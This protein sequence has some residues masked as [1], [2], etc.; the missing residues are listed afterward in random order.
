MSNKTNFDLE[1][2]FLET[3]KTKQEANRFFE[4][5]DLV[6]ERMYGVE[7]MTDAAIDECLEHT[8]SHREE[9][10]SQKPKWF[11]VL[12]GKITL[13]FRIDLL[14]SLL[15]SIEKY[16]SAAELVKIEIPFAPSE[17]F[18]DEVYKTLRS[19]RVENFLID[20]EVNRSMNGGA[21]LFVC[22][23]Y[24]NLT[25]SKAIGKYLRTKDVIKCYL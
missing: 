15:D 3:L 9:N 22:G 2:S 1:K 12:R 11:F 20:I 21:K 6:K 19:S 23:K 8:K 25:L 4:F 24:I 18:I 16:V 17:F 13:D 5:A 10:N 7:K 14:K